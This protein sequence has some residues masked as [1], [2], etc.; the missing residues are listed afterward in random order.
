LQAGTDEIWHDIITSK[1]CD[2]RSITEAA[3]KHM[4]GQGYEDWETLF[5]I[6][7]AAT[8]IN[9]PDGPFGYKNDAVLSNIRPK[10]LP[11][12]TTTINLAPGEGVFSIVYPGFTIPFN[13]GNIRY[14]SIR[15]DP[16]ALSD[17][18]IFYDGVLLT[19]N[20]NSDARGKAETGRSSGLPARNTT[21]TKFE[22]S[23]I[24]RLPHSPPLNHIYLNFSGN[25]FYFRQYENGQRRISRSGLF[26]FTDTEM[27][28]IPMQA[29]SWEGYTQRYSLSANELTLESGGRGHFGVFIKQ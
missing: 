20:A 14:M 2:F 8:Y 4:P 29:G 17:S 11:P 10:I 1:Y 21:L 18:E 13:E 15:N 26:F 25:A 23:W 3:S 6:W 7:L 16:P 12:G 22:G 9:A 27:T 5:R 24:G 19:Y 28:F